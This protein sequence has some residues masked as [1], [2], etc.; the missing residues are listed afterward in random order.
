MIF[1]NCHELNEVIAIGAITL[2]VLV[3]VLWLPPEV[4]KDIVSFGLGGIVG[5]VSKGNPPK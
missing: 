3:C 1:S 4:A 5:Y 2:I